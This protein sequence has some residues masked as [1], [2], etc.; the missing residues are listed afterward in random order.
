MVKK[1][2]G[3][4]S[5]NSGKIPIEQNNVYQESYVKE[6]GR[7]ECHRCNGTGIFTCGMCNGTGINN[8]GVE[9]GCIRNYNILTAL[10]DSNPG[11]PLRWE[12]DYCDGTGFKR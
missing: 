2:G 11:T 3:N 5:E 9:C 10:G 1:G 6:D 12:C 8:M 4:E 7:T